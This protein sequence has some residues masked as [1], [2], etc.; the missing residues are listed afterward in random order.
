[1]AKSKIGYQL[2][3]TGHNG[4][5]K[6]RLICTLFEVEDHGEH[7]LYKIRLGSFD[8]Q[9]HLLMPN[10][11][12]EGNEYAPVGTWMYSRWY[13]GRVEVDDNHYNFGQVAGKF[14]KAFAKLRT[15]VKRL[16]DGLPGDTCMVSIYRNALA[17]CFRQLQ[18]EGIEPQWYGS[19][20]GSNYLPDWRCD[21]RP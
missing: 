1:M 10:E 9:S 19:G 11:G 5:E 17:N 16:Q 18:G 14:V 4:S 13:T 7:G 3:I 12:S 6:L 2:A 8:L 15:E 21:S 20:W